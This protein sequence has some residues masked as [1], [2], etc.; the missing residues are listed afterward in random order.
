MG[1]RNDL[2]GVSLFLLAGEEDEAV[3]GLLSCCFDKDDDARFTGCDCLFFSF[4][5]L[6]LRSSSF[7]ALST[8]A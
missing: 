1:V 6:F 3:L 7:L 2:D 5:S 8:E 4:C